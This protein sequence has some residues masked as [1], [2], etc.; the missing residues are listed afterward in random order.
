MKEA[1]ER[2]EWSRT[3]QLLALTYNMNRDPKKSSA[4]TPDDW[5][6]YATRGEITGTI[7]AEEMANMVDP[8][9]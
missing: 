5:N 6:P 2:S 7:T 9:R 1:R 3:S 4:T 8:D